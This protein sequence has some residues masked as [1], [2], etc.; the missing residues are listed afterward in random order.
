MDEYNL[1]LYYEQG[2]KLKELISSLNFTKRNIAKK[3]SFHPK[4]ITT[5]ENEKIRISKSTYIKIF[6]DRVLNQL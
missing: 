1:F 2:K 3:P 4:T 6:K 5:W